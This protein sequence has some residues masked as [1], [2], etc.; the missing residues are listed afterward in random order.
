MP[1][2]PS[3]QSFQQLQRQFAGHIRDPAAVDSPAGLEDRRMEVYRS[4]FYNNIEGF[5]SSAFP[6]LHDSL[7]SS[8]WHAMVRDF[9]VR[10]ACQS[11]YFLEISQE[12]LHYLQNERVPHDADPP[13]MLELAHY[14]WVELALDVADVEPDWALIHANGD[15]LEQLPVISP[16]AW[17]LAYSYPVHQMGPGWQGEPQATFLIAYRS[18]EE[19]V[20]FMEINSVT[21]RLLEII[22]QGKVDNGRQ[23]LEQLAVEMQRVSDADFLVFGFDL[24]RQ[25]QESGILLGTEG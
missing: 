25:L 6:V 22:A 23:A 4:L 7:E 14:E 3:E 11:P 19:L 15:M 17:S 10:H 20:K 12:F 18:R 1:P 16:T 13:Y 5:I 8:H 2:E 21:S 24:L 9:M